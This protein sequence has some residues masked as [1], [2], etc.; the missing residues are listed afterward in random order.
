MAETK[1]ALAKTGLSKK[2]PVIPSKQT[3]SFTREA[4]K[5]DPLRLV[6]FVLLALVV[7][8]AAVKFGILD[9]EAKRRSAQTA[10]SDKQMQLA[11]INAKLGDFEELDAQYGR[12]S[13]GWMNESETGLVNRMDILKLLEDQVMR[14][15]TV[16]D[17]SISDN[18]LT[19]NIHGV[20]LERA[21]S[22]V[23]ELE[24]SPLVKSASVYSASAEDAQQASIFMSVILTKEAAEQ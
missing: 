1:L 5:I 2:G 18:V 12:Y 24:S 6:L 3:I 4:K 22:I 14:V 23:K 20:T 13:Y 7:I 21:S 11:E 15:A 8:A 16:E 17:Y 19:L 10:L 9:Q